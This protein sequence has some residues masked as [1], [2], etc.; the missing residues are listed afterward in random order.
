MTL[1]FKEKDSYYITVS[2]RGNQIKHTLQAIS[3]AEESGA[4]YT[5]TFTDKDLFLYGSF[6]FTSFKGE[7]FLVDDLLLDPAKE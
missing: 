3:T 6:G 5:D 7:V 1:D 2:V 4:S